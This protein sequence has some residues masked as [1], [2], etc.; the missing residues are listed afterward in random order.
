VVVVGLRL[1]SPGGQHRSEQPGQALLD[2]AGE[3]PLGAALVLEEE[4]E[5]V[6]GDGVDQ[7]QQ[8]H[9]LGRNLLAFG[10]INDRLE[11]L[12]I[13]DSRT[14]EQGVRWHQER[15]ENGKG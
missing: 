4:L 11:D 7:E 14:Y 5:R 8:V 15:M 12:K 10:T 3:V 6:L 13:R 1:R 2:R 9:P